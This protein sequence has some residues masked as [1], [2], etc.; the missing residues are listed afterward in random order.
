MHTDITVLDSLVAVHLTVNIWTARRKLVPSDFNTT[1]LPPEELASLG[2]KRI[3]NPADLR[4]FGTLKSRA[5]TLLDRNG[6]RFLGGWALPEDRIAEVQT[7][8]EGIATEFLREK[9]AFLDRY[10][11]AIRD[12]IRTNPGWESIIANSIVSADY[13]RSRFGFAWQMF[14]VQTPA[15]RDDSP[16]SIVNTGLEDVV[17]GLGQTL[18]GEIAK[19]AT[20]TWHKSFVGKT[21]VTRKALS[22]L[23][24]MYRKLTCLS[25]VEPRVSPVAD[26]LQTAFSAVGRKG[27]IMG[28]TLLMLQG[29]VSLLRDPE[30]LLEHA[31]SMLDGRNPDDILAGFT[32]PG[33]L[34]LSGN[35]ETIGAQEDY[36]DVQDEGADEMPMAPLPI[37]PQL[38]SLGLW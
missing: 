25:F 36:A 24:T 27:H 26:L 17:T 35:G 19:A 29:L 1:N 21:E 16:E 13:V 2:S 22:P 9:D 20:D 38:D 23:R 18:F 11:D 14:K 5:T 7:E 10:D 31:Q 6:V 4:V 32:G 28:P 8:L 3:C 33:S 34:V 30:A 15:V 37:G 12:W